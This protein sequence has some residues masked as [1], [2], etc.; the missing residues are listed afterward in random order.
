MLDAVVF[1]HP[2]HAITIG[3]TAYIHRIF[4][5][6]IHGSEIACQP[7]SIGE[8]KPI[9]PGLEK[10]LTRF[11]PKAECRIITLHIT[12]FHRKRHQQKP[13]DGTQQVE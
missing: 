2:E 9:A 10:G 8:I 3:G 1:Q 5:Q 6:F 12:P 11:E 4:G 7:V 13:K